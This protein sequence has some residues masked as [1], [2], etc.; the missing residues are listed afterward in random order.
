MG[1][2]YKAGVVGAG[3]MGAGIAQLL[4]YG[5]FPVVL[6]EESEEALEK[7]VA[8]IRKVYQGRVEKGK[9]TPGQLKAKMGLL[10]PTTTWNAFHDV[11][12]AIEAV[13]EEAD[14]KRDVFAQLDRACPPSAVLASNTGSL[15]IQD[16]ARSTQRPGK[17][18][19]LHFFHPVRVM[20]LVEVVSTEE[21][22]P[23]TMDTCIGLVET[24]RKIPIRVADGTGFLVNRLLMA[25]I[26]EAALALEEGAATAGEIDQAMAEFGMPMGPFFLADNLGLGICRDIA[27]SLES[28]YGERAPAPGVFDFLCEKG[29]RGMKSGAGFYSYGDA[30]EIA[31]EMVLNKK[32]IPFTTERVVL[33]MINEAMH[34]LYEG[35]ASATD[36]DMAMVAGAGF[37]IDRGGLLH[38]ADREGLQSVL[39]G[40]RKLETELGSRFRPSPV[41]ERRV[42]AKRGFFDYT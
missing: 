35:V 34:C 9:M 11:D 38:H 40:L 21:T 25:Y 22:L 12:L 24:L 30:P 15:S 36:I 18:A 19:G 33:R 32:E 29:R 2:I 37:P 8:R 13:P 10:H 42:E 16:L 4:T 20:K 26:S 31:S 27:H 1:Y 3:T 28:A 7:G 39:E 14:R 6:K 5:D 41:L 17:V 23:E